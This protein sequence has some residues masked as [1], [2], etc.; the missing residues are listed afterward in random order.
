MNFLHRYPIK[1]IRHSN[2]TQFDRETD[3]INFS[4]ENSWETHLWCWHAR[5]TFDFSAD[6]NNEDMKNILIGFFSIFYSLHLWL[7]FKSIFEVQFSSLLK[8]NDICDQEQSKGNEK[9][10]A[11]KRTYI[12]N[13]KSVAFLKNC[14]TLLLSVYNMI[15]SYSIKY[16]I[17][18]V[19]AP[20]SYRSEPFWVF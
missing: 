10:L 9:Q 4:I 17:D 16:Q 14:S 1:L 5:I 7:V 12:L 18:A 20:C 15:F 19:I 2:F 8:S 11:Y 6:R 3:P 13:M